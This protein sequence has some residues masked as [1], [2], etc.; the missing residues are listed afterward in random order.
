MSKLELARIGQVGYFGSKLLSRTT[1]G[2]QRK[3]GGKPSVNG[4]PLSWSLTWLCSRES[5]MQLITCSTRHDGSF[6]QILLKRIAST[7][8]GYFM[9]VS[10]CM[11]MAFLQIY[12]LQR[13]SMIWDSTLW[14]DRDHP[15]QAWH[16]VVWF[17]HFFILLCPTWLSVCVCATVHWF[18]KRV[19]QRCCFTFSS[20]L[21]SCPVDP[22]PSRLVS[23][24]DA[25]RPVIAAIINKPLQTGHFPED[26]KEALVHPLLKKPGLDAVNKNLRP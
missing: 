15:A 22:M 3:R 5:A 6:I 25:L 8:G 19:H 12:M 1:L 17:C 20:A 9:Q 21:K 13:L 16:W 4:D 10:A 11:M 7:N 23:N 18:W 14:L 24:C 2:K 26:W